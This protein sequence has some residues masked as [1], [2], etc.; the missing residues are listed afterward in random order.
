MLPGLLGA[1]L[2]PAIIGSKYEG[3]IYAHQT[4]AFK[5]PALVGKMGSI[6]EYSYRVP[7]PSLGFSL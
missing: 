3:A 4:L 6:N 7:P 5:R 1:S 2:F